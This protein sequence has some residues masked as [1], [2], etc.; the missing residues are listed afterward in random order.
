LSR[1]GTLGDI[2]YPR[3]PSDLTNKEGMEAFVKAIKVIRDHLASLGFMVDKP[4]TSSASLSSLAK[5]HGVSKEVLD[6]IL[7]SALAKRKRKK[8]KD[9][10]PGAEEKKKEKEKRKAEDTKP[11]VEEKKKKRKAED[12]NPGGGEKKNKKKKAS[13]DDDD[14]DE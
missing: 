8:G 9:S 3:I 5:A 10:N 11:G 6:K 1:I 7:K 4:T 14:D 12:S 13:D 2:P